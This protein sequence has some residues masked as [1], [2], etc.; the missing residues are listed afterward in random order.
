[1]KKWK[2]G[3]HGVRGEVCPDLLLSKTWTFFFVNSFIV[4]VGNSAHGVSGIGHNRKVA[5]FSSSKIKFLVIDQRFHLNHLRASPPSHL[6][7]NESTLI[8]G[9]YSCNG[10][11]IGCCYINFQIKNLRISNTYVLNS[12]WDYD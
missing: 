3:T 6:K 2:H 12:F 7:D 5:N 4:L 10:K 11:T 1:M 9:L 8:N